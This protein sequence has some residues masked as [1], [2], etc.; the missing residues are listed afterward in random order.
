MPHSMIRNVHT[1]G[2]PQ[3]LQIGDRTFC[4]LNY[5]VRLINGT[6]SVAQIVSVEKGCILMFVFV[7]SDA[8]GRDNLGHTMQSLHFDEHPRQPC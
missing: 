4:Q 7:A 6:T 3:K 2:E 5:N 8:A 1:S